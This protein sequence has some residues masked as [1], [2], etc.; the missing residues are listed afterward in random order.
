MADEQLTLIFVESKV[1]LHLAEQS[2]LPF[3]HKQKAQKNIS[4]LNNERL[5]LGLFR[6]HFLS[7]PVS[8]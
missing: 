2:R 1:D 8:L 6:T 3:W 4:K 5:A 7:S